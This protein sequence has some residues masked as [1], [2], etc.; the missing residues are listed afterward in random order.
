MKQLNNLFEA[1][2]LIALPMVLTGCE[3]LFG[4]WDKPTPTGP[5]PTPTPTLTPTTGINYVA[6]TASGATATPTAKT[7]ED[8][9]YTVVTNELTDFTADKPYVVNSDVTITGDINIKGNTDLLLCDGKTLTVNGRIKDDFASYTLSSLNIYGQTNGSGK[10]V[11]KHSGGGA[12][13]SPLTANEINIHGGDINVKTT[14]IYEYA[15]YASEMNIFSGKLKAE[16]PRSGITVQE[17]LHIYDGT[18]EATSPMYGILNLSSSGG[19]YFYG[20]N[21][22]AKGGPNYA[23]ICSDYDNASITISGGTVTA[24]GEDATDPSRGG[25]GIFVRG[26]ISI[27]GGD[28]TAKGGNGNGTGNGGSGIYVKYKGYT[29]DFTAGKLMATG[30]I[31]GGG[32]DSNAHGK[33]VYN[34]IKNNNASIVYYD[35][36]DGTSWTTNAGGINSG[37][38]LGTSSLR[39]VRL[40]VP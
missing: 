28:V 40:N 25:H 27:T 17:N 26:P 11:I 38:K 8:G 21:I 16:A 22:T 18:I 9:T 14:N 31:K 23:A 2:L 37:D 33:G 10:L 39:G 34:Y 24:I 29:L 3:E 19:M 30:G 6:Y 35:T 13:T 12:T 15:I 20:G 36:Y 5:T 4:E 1:L 32:S 7:L